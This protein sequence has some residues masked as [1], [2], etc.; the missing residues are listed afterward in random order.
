LRRRVWA[1]FAVYCLLAGSAWLLPPI[2]LE[3]RGLMFGVVG[4]LAVGVHGR[5]G[6]EWRLVVRV[7]GVAVLVEGVPAVV[8]GLAGRNVGSSLETAV[9]ALVPAIVVL[10]VAQGG[11][12]ASAWMSMAPALA[13]LSGFLLLVPL[14]F[15]RAVVGWAS[16]AVLIAC[17]AVIAIASVA[18]FPLLRRMELAQA[19]AVFCLANAMVLAVG[20][21]G[22]LGFGW[23]AGLVELG[24]AVLLAV[25]LRGMEPLRLGAR[26]LAIPLLA[27]VEGIVLLRPEL[28]LRSVAGVG[29]MVVAVVMLVIS[30]TT[31]EVSSLSLR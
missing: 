10:V 28:T 25:L 26:F 2:S 8:G 3:F 29:L 21:G 27:I 17:A 5:R 9:W 31:E 14:G 7:A 13:G 15:P 22:V 4:V 11:D 6:W 16:F 19:V 12:G 30:R 24:Q 1:M 20:G 18:V 23:V